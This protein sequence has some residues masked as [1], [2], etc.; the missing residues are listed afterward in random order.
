M[1]SET[2]R[3]VGLV[4]PEFCITVRRQGNRKVAC[5]IGTGIDILGSLRSIFISPEFR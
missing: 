3:R 2:V 4:V 5:L 1:F